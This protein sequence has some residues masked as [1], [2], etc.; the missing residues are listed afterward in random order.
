MSFGEDDLGA[1]GALTRAIGL[2]RGASGD[3]NPDWFSDPVGGTGSEHSN[4]NGFAT[5][6]SDDDQRNALTEFVDS[7]LGPPTGHD[8]DSAR[9]VPLFASDDPAVTVYAVLEPTGSASAGT[10]R[11]GVGVEHST[12][13]G[14]DPLNRVSPKVTTR[15]H[16]PIA[17]VARGTDSRPTDGPNPSWLLLGR[18]GGR[19]GV[20][21][22]A[23]FT[24]AAPVAGE[25]FLRG[26]SVS[27]GIPTGPEPV[28]FSLSLTDLQLPGATAPTT[29]TLT[30]DDLATVGTD[31][32]EFI[33]GLV[34]ARLLPCRRPT[35]RW[36][37]CAPSRGCSACATG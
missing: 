34:R 11:I 20:E 23:T 8:D 36:P 12:G 25:A 1:F 27:V 6:L 3:N 33:V 18:E 19:I 16:V 24:D 26:M 29:R 13:S 31:L 30:L 28:A 4:A 35:W 17:H 9:W 10:V 32:I 37:R 5:I 21:V 22:E 7:T 15:L 14:A 2:T